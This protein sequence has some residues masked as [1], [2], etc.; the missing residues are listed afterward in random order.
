MK[1]KICLLLSMAL[2]GIFLFASGC[3]QKNLDEFLAGDIYRRVPKT[4]HDEL[5]P[6]GHEPTPDKNCF[7]SKTEGAYY[8]QFDN[9]YFH[10]KN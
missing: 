5:Y 8:C 9:Q 7:F 2:V 10:V 6:H 1:R 4:L 3:S